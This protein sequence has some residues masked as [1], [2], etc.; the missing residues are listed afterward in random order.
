MELSFKRLCLTSHE[1]GKPKKMRIKKSCFPED[2]F[3]LQETPSFQERMRGRRD[4]TAESSSRI[5]ACEIS[6][7]ESALPEI[8]R[9]RSVH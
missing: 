9:C 5:A 4:V 7:Q 1:L 6:W 8:K 3:K 2:F